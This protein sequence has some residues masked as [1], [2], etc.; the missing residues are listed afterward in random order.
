[1]PLKIKSLL[2]LAQGLQID[3]QKMKDYERKTGFEIKN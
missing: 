3:A 1:M 2:G